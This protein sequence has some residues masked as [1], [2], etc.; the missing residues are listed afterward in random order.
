LC[1]TKYCLIIQRLETLLPYETV[2][3]EIVAE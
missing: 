1:Y 3:A 2:C